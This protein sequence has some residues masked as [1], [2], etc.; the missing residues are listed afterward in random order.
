[1]SWK[2]LAILA[3]P[4]LV[5]DAAAPSGPAMSV[6]FWVSGC[7]DSEGVEATNVGKQDD[8]EPALNKA[9]LN[10]CQQDTRGRAPG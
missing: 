7:S 9:A 8:P 3:A 6:G 10:L 5:A 2:L 1:M 4:L